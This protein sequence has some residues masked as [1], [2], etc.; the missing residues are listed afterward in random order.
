MADPCPT[1]VALWEVR[2]AFRKWPPQDDKHPSVKI[3]CT[4]AKGKRNQ[5]VHSLFRDGNWDG[6]R[7][8]GIPN[9]DVLKIMMANL[10]R[11]IKTLNTVQDLATR[12]SVLRRHKLTIN[13]LFIYSSY[14]AQFSTLMRKVKLYGKRTVGGMGKNWKEKTSPVFFAKV[15]WPVCFLRLARVGF[16]W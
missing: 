15:W 2:S 8:Q 4:S 13:Y 7:E 10:F 9:T 16:A 14:G 11:G 5:Y 6:V 1:A 3:S 12:Q